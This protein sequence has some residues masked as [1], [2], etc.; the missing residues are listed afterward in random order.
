MVHHLIAY[1]PEDGVNKDW[2]VIAY[3]TVAISKLKA[4]VSRTEQ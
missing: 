3:E 1:H 2:G 4:L